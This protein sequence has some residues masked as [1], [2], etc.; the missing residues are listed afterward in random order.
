MHILYINLIFLSM[1][2]NKAEG[3]QNPSRRLLLGTVVAFAA[4]SAAAAVKNNIL[5]P[6][7]EGLSNNPDTTPTPTSTLTPTTQPTETPTPQPTKEKPDLGFNRLK[8]ILALLLASKERLQKEKEYVGWAQT[9][10]QIDNGFLGVFD[11]NLRGKLLDKRFAIRE[12]GDPRLHLLSPDDRDW[13]LKN[14]YHPESMAICIDSYNEAKDILKSKFRE[15]GGGENFYSLFRPDLVTMANTGHQKFTKSDLTDI[16]TRENSLDEMLIN[17]GGMLYLINRETGMNLPPSNLR[18]LFVNLGKNPADK[19]LARAYPEN[20]EPGKAKRLISALEKICQ[21][22]SQKGLIYNADNVPGSELSGDIGSYQALPETFLRENE[23]FEQNFGKTW[24]P[25]GLEATVLAY[26]FLAHGWAW[27]TSK[28]EQKYQIGYLKNSIDGKI[29]KQ[30]RLEALIKW[31]GNLA[32][33]ALT[34]ANKY[35]DEVI[36]PGYLA[37]KAA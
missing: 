17:P 24:N 37:K 7:R 6:I 19:M 25:F 8:E 22:L 9:L 28:G 20:K 33:D 18:Y 36:Y 15:P 5:Q 10:E 14:G 1:S 21:K 30:F 34:W 4:A 16:Q 32:E 35:Y 12:K 23:F 27:K 3:P 29:R 26:L 2:E 13:A 31:N 11:V